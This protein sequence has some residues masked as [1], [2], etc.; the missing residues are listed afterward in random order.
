MPK[1]INRSGMSVV[2][3]MVIV[4]II[5]IVATVSVP[6]YRNASMN[7][8]LSGAARTIASDLRYAQQLSVTTQINHSVAFNASANTY[9]II[10]TATNTIVKSEIIRQPI[11]I[12]SISGLAGNT[13]AFNATGAA[14]S[15]GIISLINTGGKVAEIEI[16]PSG[17]VEIH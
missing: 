1:H 14:M 5:G 15:T 12:K 9:S 7:L 6:F 4:A 11:S 8:T 2:E 3:I 16:K 10:N 17:Y 13:A